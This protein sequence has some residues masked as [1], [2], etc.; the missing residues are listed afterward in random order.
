MLSRLPCSLVLGSA[1]A[2]QATP[3]I[4]FN[5]TSTSVSAAITLT[6]FAGPNVTGFRFTPTSALTLQAVE[7]FTASQFATTSGYMTVEIWDENPATTLPGTR[8]AGGTWQC[9]SNLGL[10]WHGANLDGIAVLQL[11][12]NYWLVWREPGGSRVP[13]ETGG[14][15]MSTARFLNNAW[16]AQAAAQPLKW[17]GHCSQLASATAVPVGAGC[18]SSTGS[19]PAAFTNHDAVQGNADFQFEATGFAPGTIGVAILGTNPF[20]PSIPVPGTPPNCAVHNEALVLL[21]V[22]VGTGNQQAQ[23]TTGAAGHCWLDVPIP[24][25]PALTGFTLDAQFAGLDA[26]AVRVH[27]RRARDAVNTRRSARALAVAR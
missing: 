24:A 13:Y 6:G 7:I 18:A 4:A 16:V 17:R 8:L 14:T 11:A 12:Q 23:H 21:V 2:A 25:D 9:H 27:E 19:V 3:C 22:P 1:L 26:A 15:V 20:W 10:G 5:D